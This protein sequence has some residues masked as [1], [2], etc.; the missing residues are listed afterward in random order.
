MTL[1]SSADLSANLLARAAR[2]LGLDRLLGSK[3]KGRTPGV[4]AHVTE[5]AQPF[6]A[7]SIS[8]Q[9]ASSK[10]NLWIVCRTEREQERFYGELAT[11]IDN[12]LLFP[13]LE[14]AAVEGAIPD[15]ET[16]AERLAV[17]QKISERE[18]PWVIVL[19]QKSLDDEVYSPEELGDL[20]VHLTVGEPL[21]RQ[22]LLDR[23]VQAGYE[24]TSQVAERGQYSIRGGIVD[25]YAWQLVQPLRIEWFGDE[26]TSIREF[27]LD[28]QSSIQ[29][30]TACALV[31]SLPERQSKKLREYRKKLDVVLSVEEA[32]DGSDL[33]IY[34][35]DRP[36]GNGDSEDYTLAF[37]ESPLHPAKNHAAGVAFREL[38]SKH[39]H[40][41]FS[42]W[43]N[44]GW[45]ICIQYKKRAEEGEIKRFI[46]VFTLKGEQVVLRLSDSDGSFAFPAGKLAVVTAGEIFC[47]AQAGAATQPIAP[48][49]RRGLT[50]QR[51]HLNYTNLK[52]GDLVVHLEHGLAKYRGT[53]ARAVSIRSDGEHSASTEEF[54][55]LEFAEQA[56]LFVPLEQAFLVS[57]YVGIGKRGA[58]LSKLGDG[59]WSNTK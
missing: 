56:K 8:R 3:R 25:V 18:K 16:S 44:E 33:T 20:A 9:Y 38:N 41:Q 39:V 7:A 13:H 52:F 32:F 43:L 47:Y 24:A 4:F 11:W 42:G 12:A 40:E 14:V 57:R 30:L 49:N 2:S 26:I 23:L 35:G 29:Q 5:L 54:M 48:R 22:V 45:Q 17:L 1:Q 21:D 15:P 58:V 28:Q 19:N 31:L 36:A 37:F 6:V 53:E 34:S 50:R 27:D 51:V 10:Q 55:V 59:K 46:D